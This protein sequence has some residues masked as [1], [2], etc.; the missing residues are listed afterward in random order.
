MLRSY[1]YD[2]SDAYIVV[3]GTADLLSAAA[4][5]NDKAEKLLP[6]KIML[7]S[8]HALQKLTLH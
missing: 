6:L 5:E 8:N 4:N 2:Y 7:H 1:L 3:I